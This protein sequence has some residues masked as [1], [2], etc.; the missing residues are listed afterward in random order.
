MYLSQNHF[1]ISNYPLVYVCERVE[2]L[3]TNPEYANT[4]MFL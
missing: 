3:L 1:G 4:D 2:G